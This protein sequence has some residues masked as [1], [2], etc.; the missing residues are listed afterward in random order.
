MLRFHLD[1]HVHPA[2]A[3]G[4]RAH[5]VDVTMSSDVGLLGADDVVHLEF[6]YRETRV[7]VT[8]DDDFLR[9]HAA[10]AAHGGIAYCHQ[11]KHS[12]GELLRMLLLLGECYA[13]NEMQGRAE[14]L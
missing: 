12:L 2:I 14:Y 13:E 6:S 10:G 5:G 9:H 1:E 7:I 8:H 3:A 11:Q 4:L